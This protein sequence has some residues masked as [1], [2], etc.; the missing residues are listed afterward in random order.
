M[1]PSVRVPAV[2]F[3]LLFNRPTVV[4]PLLPIV[5]LAVTVILPEPKLLTTFWVVIMPP[6]TVT[7]PVNPLLSPVRKT[8][9]APDLTKL[10][11]PAKT[12]WN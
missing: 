11:E 7:V 1:R 5:A 10:P 9:P 12:P 8:S 3:N 6:L 2:T 4:V